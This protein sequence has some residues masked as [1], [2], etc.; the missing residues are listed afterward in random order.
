[1][2]Y[3]GSEELQSLREELR[4]ERAAREEAEAL[5]Q[6]WRKA[7]I[8]AK[9][10]SLHAQPGFTYDIKTLLQNVPESAEETVDS[11]AA[12]GG[13]PGN[14][15][16]T[17]GSAPFESQRSE[18]RVGDDGLGEKVKDESIPV[19][20][21]SVKGSALEGKGDGNVDEADID[22]LRAELR[23]LRE[24]LN[25]AEDI[26]VEQRNALGYSESGELV[27]TPPEEAAVSKE[28]AGRHVVGGQTIML[29]SAAIVIASGV[30][31]FLLQG[32]R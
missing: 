8:D 21:S 26:I 29:A 27:Y 5:V 30:I 3:T 28:S 32:K 13:S 6:S 22:A 24:L 9:L 12:H 2:S 18:M 20:E 1:M 23:H 11:S 15:R 31:A 19:D 17:R 10:S 4:T 25:A 7:S 14:T 16:S